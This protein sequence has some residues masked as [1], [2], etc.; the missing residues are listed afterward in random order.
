MDFFQYKNTSLLSGL[1][2]DLLGGDWGEAEGVS[3]FLGL[4]G[5]TSP[6]PSLLPLPSG[7]PR[8]SDHRGTSRGAGDVL[9]TREFS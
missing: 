3:F 1:L 5:A 7:A 8:E 9:A 6:S 4:G 2:P